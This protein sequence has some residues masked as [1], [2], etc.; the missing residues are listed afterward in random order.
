M[1]FIALSFDDGPD[2]ATAQILDLLEWH[3]A[4]ATF[5]VLGRQVEGREE[6]LRRAVKAGHELGNHTFSHP[7]LEKLASAQ[8]E[9]E[10]V[11]ASAAIEG[12][13]GFRPRLM[14]PPYGLGEHQAR[15]VARR[16]GMK[17]VRWSL[18]PTDWNEPDPNRISEA[19]LVGAR[20]GAI[21]VLHDGAAHG[22]DRSP[23]VAALKT[24]VPRLRDTG[25]RF[26]TMSTL[27]R[28]APWATRTAVPRGRLRSAIH[29]GRRWVGVSPT[30]T[31]A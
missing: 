13:V 31:N 6:V 10:L 25:Y 9:T 24:A 2:D 26:T 22:G 19:I 14:R 20:S 3:G 21:V 15:S 8:I 28:L 12:A 30:G 18:N 16:L 7:N 4:H 27:L 11:R 17:T 23:T 1:K 5:F 29:S